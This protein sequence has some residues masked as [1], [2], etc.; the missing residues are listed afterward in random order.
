MPA[1]TITANIARRTQSRVHLIKTTQITPS[2]YRGQRFTKLPI[3]DPF[4]TATSFQPR[5]DI[6][7]PEPTPENGLTPQQRARRS[8]RERLQSLPLVPH[9]Q[10]F[11]WTTDIGGGDDLQFATPRLFGKFHIKEFQI[12][13]HDTVGDQFAWSMAELTNAATSFAQHLTGT[14]L[15]PS[16]TPIFTRDDQLEYAR[17]LRNPQTVP[18]N[19][20]RTIQF[21]VI[22]INISGLG[23]PSANRIAIH[24]TLDDISS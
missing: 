3:D 2:E 23:G 13:S 5:L 6:D 10:T 18:I 4:V 8:R 22:S 20:T 19:I 15:L 24:L 9:R 11:S 1:P 16:E 14:M 17:N 21:K 12:Y 7:P